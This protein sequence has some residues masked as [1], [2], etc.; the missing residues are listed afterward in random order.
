MLLTTY[1]STQI[2][3]RTIESQVAK[4]M[5]VCVLAYL[6]LLILML[7]CP[8]VSAFVTSR[9]TLSSRGIHERQT[10]NLHSMHGCPAGLHDDGRIDFAILHQP[11]SSTVQPTMEKSSMSQIWIQTRKGRNTHQ[12][13]GK[14]KIIPL[15]YTATLCLAKPQLQPRLCKPKHINKRIQCAHCPECGFH[16]KAKTR[17][18]TRYN[19][20]TR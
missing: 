11:T 6:A 7:L 13:K 16:P 17:N 2:A 20:Q 10:T 14:T 8:L 9:T 5:P 4:R 15:R 12:V 3:H 18:I 19:L 1:Q